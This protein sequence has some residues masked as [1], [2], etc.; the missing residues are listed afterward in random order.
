MPS[1]SP[2]DVPTVERSQTAEINSDIC[3]QYN[4]LCRCVEIYLACHGRGGHSLGK[5]SVQAGIFLCENLAVSVEQI[6]HCVTFAGA[7][8]IFTPAQG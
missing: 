8:T 2:I 6:A 7:A 5:N 4:K 3:V 1:Q